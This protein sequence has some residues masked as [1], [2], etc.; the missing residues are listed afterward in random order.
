MPIQFSSS[1]PFL[2]VVPGLQDRQSAHF[3]PFRPRPQPKTAS[4]FIVEWIDLVPGRNAGVS[5]FPVYPGN[6]RGAWP[7]RGAF[8]PPDQAGF[9]ILRPSLR[10]LAGP[11]SSAFG[12]FLEPPWRS[13]PRTGRAF[14]PR[15]ADADGPPPRGGPFVHAGVGKVVLQTLPEHFMKPHGRMA[16]CFGGA[17]SAE[18]TIEARRDVAPPSLSTTVFGKPR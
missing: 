9:P 14:P 6:R 8:G 15:G 12:F 18:Q 5:A 1:N 16:G 17:A 11:R 13:P 7:L 4:D 3:T 2:P 10:T